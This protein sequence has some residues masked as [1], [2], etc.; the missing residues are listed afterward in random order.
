M[1][2]RVEGKTLEAVLEG[3]TGKQIWAMILK[4]WAEFGGCETGAQNVELFRA[5]KL[6]LKLEPIGE[7]NGESVAASIKRD[8]LPSELLAA[9]LIPEYEDEAGK[10][11]KW[12]VV[13][14]VAP[15]QFEV[16]DLEYVSFLEPDDPGYVNGEV[17]RARAVVLKAN[18][19][20]VDGKRML[21]CQ[22]E[23]P[24]EMQDKIIVLPGTL[25][26]GRR[27]GL[28]VACLSWVGARWVLD[29]RWV[30]YGFGASYLL[31]RGK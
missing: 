9:D 23:I 27:G 12:E 4:L 25:L 6:R 10:K 22:A 17:M 28:Y 13:E 11:R 5:G 26:R 19:G 29:V 15:S 2:S 16:K 31:P 14:D 1:S 20:L 30:V 8:Q 3:L 18:Y 7:E 24:K 21:E